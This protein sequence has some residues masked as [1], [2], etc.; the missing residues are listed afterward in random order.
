MY[1]GSFKRI[2]E[3]EGE[4]NQLLAEVLLESKEYQG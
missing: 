3:K 1:A 4:S 2:L